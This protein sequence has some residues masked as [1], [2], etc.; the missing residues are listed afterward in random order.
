MSIS[1]A[2]LPHMSKADG[3]EH[4]VA[5]YL[6]AS[7]TRGLRQIAYFVIPSA[8]AFLA[9]GDVLAALLFQRGKF[10]AADSRY[11]WG[12]LAGA[13]IG[14]LAS[15]MGR[16]YSSTYYALRDTRT[17]LRFALVRVSLTTVLGYFFALW[18]PPRVGLDAHWGAAGLTA[19]AG[20]AGWIE[21]ALLRSRLNRRIGATGIPSRLILSLWASAS[22]GALAGWEMRRLTVHQGHL[23]GGVL[24]LGTYGLVFL[25]MTVALGIPEA[26][27]ALAR[28]RRGR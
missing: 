24:V 7:L 4:A 14:L 16:L 11:A 26:H 3:D 21:F 19:S 27:T 6:R 22:V 2:Q 10:T 28:I 8:A 25:L 15:T 20:I 5:A 1:A 18:L 13:A 17:P 23:V 12:I 9:F